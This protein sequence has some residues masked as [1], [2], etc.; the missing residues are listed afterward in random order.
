M[1]KLMHLVAHSFED[2]LERLAPH[3][4]R[5]PFVHLHLEN[6]DFNWFLNE[7]CI[8]DMD[9][10]AED[11]D[12]VALSHYRRILDTHGWEK[13]SSQQCFAVNEPQLGTLRMTYDLYHCPKFLD[14]FLARV[15]DELA[16]MLH[17]FFG[18]F[19][20]AQQF[21]A[22]SMFLLPKS[23]FLEWQTFMS[24]M[25]KVMCSLAHENSQ[26]QLFPQND[27]Y[28]RRQGAFLSERL[29]SFWLRELSGLEVIPRSYTLLDIPS[30]Y[31]RA[32]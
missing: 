19:Q 7:S 2:S 4:F 31:Q 16:G 5:L 6:W 22:R 25:H 3:L 30:P 10:P 21:Y 32:R 27:R 12:F 1:K 13:L 24:S 11:V 23:K 17:E 29:T 20:A 14:A 8:A 9:I 15:P 28:Q 26:L 18:S